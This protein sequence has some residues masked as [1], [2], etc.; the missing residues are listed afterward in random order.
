MRITRISVGDLKKT[1][2]LLIIKYL[3]EL[4]KEVVVT[5]VN[6][7]VEIIKSKLGVTDENNLL[8]VDINIDQVNDRVREWGIGTRDTK[9]NIQAVSEYTIGTIILEI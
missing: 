7:V 4:S 5:K 2:G 6:A 1:L 3:G 8:R 9:G